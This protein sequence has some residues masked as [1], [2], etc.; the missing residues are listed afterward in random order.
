MTGLASG[1]EAESKRRRLVGR[2]AWLAIGL[3]VL[4]AAGAGAWA[5]RRGVHHDLYAAVFLPVVAR[6]A[7]GDDA[8]PPDEVAARLE[9]FV[10]VSIRSLSD[11]DMP[12]TG[13]ASQDILLRGYGYCD[14]SVFAFIHLL[15]EKDVSSAMTFLYDANGVSV[16]TVAEVFLGG[17]WRVFDTL[18]GFVPRRADGALATVREVASNPA[19][20]TGS[21]ASAD[22]YRDA[23]VQLLRGPERRKRGMPILTYLRQAGVRRLVALTPAWVIDALQDLY[24]RL[25]PPRQSDHRFAQ[26]SPEYRL[27]FRARNYHVFRRARAAEA[28]YEAILRT[29]P[30]G[31]HTD[32]VLYELGHLRLLE[33]GDARGGLASLETLLATHPGTPWA[34]D[35]RYFSARAREAL[36]DCLGAARLYREAAGGLSNGLEDAR[37]RLARLPCH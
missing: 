17:K 19:L 1:V 36:G 8:V 30:E 20:L 9:Q 7:A 31:G 12:E 10:Y 27:F 21:R 33:L 3:L 16:H 29:Y 32:D 37:A 6:R 35:A 23:R 14:Q 11:S 15:Q 25:P 5:I 4:V 18:F 26:G 13:D 2:R 22:W 34:E 24:L 28:A